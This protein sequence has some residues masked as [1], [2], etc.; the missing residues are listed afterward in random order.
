MLY[1]YSLYVCVDYS[2]LLLAWV[3]VNVVCVCL[4]L[5]CCFL[6]SVCLF[7]F[8]FVIGF[9]ACADLLVCLRDFAFCFAFLLF[10]MF[11]C[12]FMVDLLFTL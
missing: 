6:I 9:V 5:F 8:W 3:F 12:L 7:V 11:V 2:D 4:F 1:Y 10:V